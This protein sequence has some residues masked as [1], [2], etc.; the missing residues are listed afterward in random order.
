MSKLHGRHSKANNYDSTFSPSPPE[1]HQVSHLSQRAPKEEQAERH[2]VAVR[3]HYR[4]AEK[5]LRRRRWDPPKKTVPDPPHGIQSDDGKN[6]DPA[7][8]PE[9]APGTIVSQYSRTSAEIAATGALLAL[10][11]SNIQNTPEFLDNHTLRKHVPPLNAERHVTNNTEG[12]VLGVALM[13]GSQKD[14]VGAVVGLQITLPLPLPAPNPERM[15]EITWSWDD[16]RHLKPGM[17]PAGAAPL[18][19]MQKINLERTG[20]V[21]RL[22]CVQAAQVRVSEINSGP[23]TQPTAD[24]TISWTPVRKRIWEVFGPTVGMLDEGNSYLVAG[25]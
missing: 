11:H 10:N 3:T 8:E 13:Q 23:L 22:S 2:R 5:Q 6:P 20:Y 25:R 14:V 18:T 24:D 7:S 9:A 1:V 16:R 19:L 15:R 17:L 4:K 21:G 12:S